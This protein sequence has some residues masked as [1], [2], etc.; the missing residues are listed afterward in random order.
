MAVAV[1]AEL[2]LAD[3]KLGLAAVADGPMQGEV[4][5]PVVQKASTK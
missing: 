3:V 5:D 1:D 2:G 4:V